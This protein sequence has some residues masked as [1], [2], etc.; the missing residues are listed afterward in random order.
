MRAVVYLTDGFLAKNRSASADEVERAMS[1]DDKN[2]P[3]VV[4]TEEQSDAEHLPARVGDKDSTYEGLGEL[5]VRER[6]ISLA[7]LE[8]AA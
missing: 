5:L 1:T 2:L 8:D 3:A 4:N 7:Q 6:V